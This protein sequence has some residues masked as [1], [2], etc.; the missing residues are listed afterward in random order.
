VSG[1]IARNKR[2][3][4]RITVAVA[5]IG[6]RG[7]HFE[8]EVTERQ[9]KGGK[10]VDASAKL[11]LQTGDLAR[12]EQ[13]LVALDKACTFGCAEYSDLKKAI[14]RYKAGS[15]TSSSY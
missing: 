5:T 11:Y 15:R 10:T 1:L 4:V 9:E 14:A 12:A 2:Q 13:R 7:T 8:G 6:I 3:N